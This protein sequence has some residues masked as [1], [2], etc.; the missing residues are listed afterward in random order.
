M[1]LLEPH[2]LGKRFSW[3]N[4]DGTSMHSLDRFLLFKEWICFLGETFQWILQM[5]YP[6]PFRLLNIFLERG[7]HF[8]PLQAKKNR[9]LPFSYLG[10]PIENN[11]PN[12]SCWKKVLDIFKSKLAGW[13]ARHISYYGQIINKLTRL[14]RDFLRGGDDHTRKVAWVKWDE[15]MKPTKK[16]GLGIKK[17]HVFNE[18]LLLKWRW[19]FIQAQDGGWTKVIGEKFMAPMCLQRP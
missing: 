7:L 4:V 12:P 19:R 16:G 6:R 15:V 13:N 3:M 14:Q 1:D 5:D 10:F 17:L 11:P 8:P 18:A 2:V 9:K